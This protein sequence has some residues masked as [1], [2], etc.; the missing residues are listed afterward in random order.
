MFPAAAIPS[1]DHN[2]VPL[3][4]I[5][6]QPVGEVSDAAYLSVTFNQAMVPLVTLESL[7]GANVPVELTPPV[8]GRWHWVGSR[9]IRFDPVTGRLPAAT[10]F[11]ATIP[12]SLTAADGTTL[13]ESIEW[14]F[15]TP[16]PEIVDFIGARSTDDTIWP[17]VSTEPVFVAVFD[18]RV[19]A[20]GVAGVATITAGEESLPLRIATSDELDTNRAARV[21]FDAAPEGF[22]VALR[23]TSALPTATEFTLTIGPG[24][25]S[26]EGPRTSLTIYRY[27][28]TTYG[29]LIIGSSDCSSPNCAAGTGFEIGFNNELDTETLDAAALRDIIS[30]EPPL[31]GARIEVSGD[32]IAITGNTQAGTTYAVTFAA[33]LRDAFG[34]A[35]AEETAVTFE[36]TEALPMFAG[37]DLEFV[38]VDP[39]LG[40]PGITVTTVNQDELS[41]TV[42]AVTPDDYADYREYRQRFWSGERPPM[43]SWQL[44]RDETITIDGEPNRPTPTFIDL[45]ADY[46]QVGSQVVVQIEPSPAFGPR[47][48][49]Y[50][51]NRPLVAW[52]QN[53]TL[54]VDAFVDGH[55][56]LIWTT[57][58]VTG[59]PVPNVPVQLLGDGRIATTDSHGVVEVALTDVAVRG[60]FANAG[61]QVAFSPSWYEP[62]WTA[63]PADP[64]ARWFLFDDRGTYR[65]GE[66]VRLAGLLRTVEPVTNTVELPTVDSVTFAASDADGNE[67]ATG[68]VDV[69]PVGEFQVDLTIPFSASLGDAFVE[70]RAGDDLIGSHQI[71]VAHSQPP[72]V[73]VTTNTE[74]AGPH[75]TD[76]VA[77][78]SVN[79]QYPSGG[80]LDDAQV[81]WLVATRPSTFAPP[82]WDDY[83]FGINSGNGGGCDSCTEAS[84]EEFRGQT[85]GAGTHYL[86]LSFEDVTELPTTVAAEATVFDTARQTSTSTTELLVHPGAY[87]VGIRDDDRFVEAGAPVSVDAVVVDIDGNEVDLAAVDDASLEI[88]I[89]NVASGEPLTS[90]STVETPCTATPDIGGEYRLIARVTDAQGRASRTEVSRWVAGPAAF[91]G[92]NDGVVL[93]ADRSSYQ[94][95]DTASVLVIAPWA[96]GYGIANAMHGSIKTTESFTIADHIATIDVP[97]DDRDAPAVSLDVQVVG[98]TARLDATGA[99]LPDAP[100]QPAS[101][102]GRVDLLVP[103]LAH[104]LTVKPLPDQEQVEPGTTTTMSVAVTDANGTPV[105]DASVV[106]VV[107]DEDDA[108][109]DDESVTPLDVFYQLPTVGLE[110]QHARDSVQLDHEFI[111]HEPDTAP[112]AAASSDDIDDTAASDGAASAD[113]TDDTDP[114]TNNP[115]SVALLE[116]GA[117][118]D[119]EG[120]AAVDVVIPDRLTSYRIVAFAVDGTDRFGVGESSLT[121]RLP[122]QVEPRTP[123]RLRVGDEVELPVVVRNQTDHEIT[124]DVAIES[125]LLEFPDG[126]GRQV[127]VP[128]NGRIEVRF[129]ASPVAVGNARYRVGALSAAPDRDLRDIATGT[130]AIDN[131]VTAQRHATDGRVIVDADAFAVAQPFLPPSA[132]FAQLGGLGVE[133]ASTATIQ[134]TDA[135]TAL[136]DDDRTADTAAARILALA[137]LGTRDA[138][139]QV[140]DDLRSL[141]D[142]QRGD[143]GWSL[144]PGAEE[145]W[146]W[147]SVRATHALVVADRAGYAVADSDLDSALGFISEIRGAHGVRAEAVMVRREAGQSEDATTMAASIYLEAGPD[148]QPDALALLWPS[149]ND[150]EVRAEIE[151]R[152]E[153][154]ATE[155]DAGVTFDATYDESEIPASST[156]T[157]ALVLS[158]LVSES[159][160][161]PLIEPTIANLLGARANGRW[162]TSV[163]NAYAITALSEPMKANDA[164]SPAF[165]ARAWLGETD[166]LT[167][168]FDSVDHAEVD[169]SMVDVTG[170]PVGDEGTTDIIVERIGT[171]DLYYHLSL[172]A[173]PTDLQLDPTDNGIIVERIFEPTDRPTDVIRNADGS[174]HIRAGA[175]VRVRLT[176]VTTDSRRHVKVADRLAAG[177]EPVSPSVAV[178]EWF[179]FQELTDGGVLAVADDLPAGSYEYTYLARASIPGRFVAP[180]AMAAERYQPD[181]TGSTGTD[182]IIIN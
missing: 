49:L 118:T 132:V 65:P 165:T 68:T 137:T 60:L 55:Q 22:A 92:M 80:A 76:E 32:G 110:A 64:V 114:I 113:T 173:A 71:A 115:N 17:T 150:P 29:P 168:R 16:A 117:L 62:G 161:S 102:S 101:A 74:T 79:A 181:I 58:L 84:Y 8:D 53:T 131:P 44:L 162:A 138:D 126:T 153:S 91:D 104:M 18:Q 10:E 43:P 26:A 169:I 24:I 88:T 179:D 30:I 119:G 39:G 5:H 20:S 89:E 151:R 155:T 144:W 19:I 175:A 177:L 73:E 4:V 69:G 61:E 156:R 83:R 6:Q 42:W 124:V 12:A 28:A 140:R 11:D 96:Q 158:A 36:V 108:T 52:V 134:L 100:P 98:S 171:G 163:D 172:D 106:V 149:I 35:L 78:I 130:F 70:L 99:P 125:T 97:I 174:W 75:I 15:A 121:A 59:K 2:D 160:D 38:T 178:D 40:T 66:S 139:Q 14:T 87:Y 45:S 111:G 136:I 166:V 109:T 77:T 146:P 116:T 48:E 167:H 127:S 176:I 46:A 34:Q 142:T 23:P 93:V 90:C 152:I 54:A 95:G 112:T 9:T 180:P 50:W 129:P 72:H 85:D 47:D 25:S 3:E 159:P 154:A 82:G 182:R 33:D 170:L 81:N 21:A 147:L 157:D 135:V 120:I 148:L 145:S 56:L 141:I 86:Q 133:L 63:A 122:L 94:P 143:G 31:P 37:P 27:Q 13:G 57:D 123:T 107:I 164:A 128:A 51:N 1:D 67:F 7:T 105:E 103:P 41:L